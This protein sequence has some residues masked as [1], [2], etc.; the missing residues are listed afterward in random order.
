[1]HAWALLFFLIAAAASVVS[2]RFY[3]RVGDYPL[4]EGGVM[5]RTRFMALV[6][7]FT[8][9]LALI[10]I[11]MQWMPIFILRSCIGT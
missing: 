4:T 9:S 7:L 3:E 10:E 6:G 5:P 8:S 1:L 2:W 11:V